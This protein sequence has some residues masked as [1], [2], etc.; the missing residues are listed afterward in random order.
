METT[1]EKLKEE[2]EKEI[3]EEDESSDDED[4]SRD[5]GNDTY[6]FEDAFEFFVTNGDKWRKRLT[7]PFIR[8]ERKIKKEEVN[9][10]DGIVSSVGNTVREDNY[11]SNDESV[12]GHDLDEIDDYG[13]SGNEEVVLRYGRDGENND[14]I[15]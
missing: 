11:E 9:D 1:E 4:E 6:T 15:F 5:D 12:D 10:I 8:E 13:D 14:G 3:R 2:E 7:I